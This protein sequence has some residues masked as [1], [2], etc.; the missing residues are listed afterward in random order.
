MVRRPSAA[1]QVAGQ[2]LIGLDMSGSDSKVQVRIETNNLS[3]D[4]ER[5]AA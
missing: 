2:P 4:E 3:S 1:I 5:G